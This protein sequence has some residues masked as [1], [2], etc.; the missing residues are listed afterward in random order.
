MP[1]KNDNHTS[2]AHQEAFSDIPEQFLNCFENTSYANDACATFIKKIDDEALVHL[3]IDYPDISDRENETE[4]RFSVTVIE[5][6]A[7][8]GDYDISDG[9]NVYEGNSLEDVAVTIENYV[10]LD[11]DVIEECAKWDS[12]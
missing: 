11:E 8:N 12:H 1:N 9:E 6:N 5:G 2:I 10:Q 4:T 3:I 7:D